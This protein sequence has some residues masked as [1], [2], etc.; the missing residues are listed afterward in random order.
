M[1]KLEVLVQKLCDDA[2]I[3]R[4]AHDGDA[5]VDLY[6]RTAHSLKPG[7]RAL[8]PTG[9][10]LSIPCGYEGQVRPK[11]GLALKH[12]I[13]VLNTPGTVDAPYRGEVGVIIINHDPAAVYEIKKGEKVAQMIFNKVECAAF[14]EVA[15]LDETSRGEGGFGST[16]NR[17]Q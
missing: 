13:T 17:P 1:K 7:E 14:R 8:V 3:P 11:S 5:G 12:G 2:V 4:Y 9:L 15:L 6:A 16:G 10:K